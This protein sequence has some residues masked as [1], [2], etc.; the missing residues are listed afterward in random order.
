MLTEFDSGYGEQPFR[1][2]CAT[3][4][5]AQAYDPQDFRIEWGPIFRSARHGC[6]GARAAAPDQ[7]GWPYGGR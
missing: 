3:Y 2:L 7:A 1:D 4:P 5:G 6:S